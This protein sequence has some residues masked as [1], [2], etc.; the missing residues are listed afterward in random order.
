MG[1]PKSENVHPKD[2]LGLVT[3]DPVSK[4]TK[5]LTKQ[6]QQQQNPYQARVKTM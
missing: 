2:Q 5:A 6:Q 1:I 4:P 3:E